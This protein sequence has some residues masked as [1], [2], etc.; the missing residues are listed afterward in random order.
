MLGS[1]RFSLTRMLRT[2]LRRERGFTLVEILI[3]VVI[4]GI[5]AAIVIPRFSDASHQARENMLKDDL[6]YLRL[7]V[8]V[9]KAQHRDLAPGYA[10]GDMSQAPTEADFAAQMTQ[11]SNEA[12]AT[13]ATPS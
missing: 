10:A 6:R 8:Q 9:Y 12:C 1:R 5:L 3:V 2:D 4:L 13:S 11:F 7:Q